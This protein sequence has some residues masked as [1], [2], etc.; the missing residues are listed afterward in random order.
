V[1]LYMHD[2]GIDYTCNKI[3]DHFKFPKYFPFDFQQQRP[4]YGVVQEC[5]YNGGNRW[6]REQ[7]MMGQGHPSIFIGPAQSESMMHVDARMTRFWMAMINGTKHWHMFHPRDIPNLYP[8]D[9][10]FFP[11][12]FDVDTFR[13]DLKK[14]PKL[15]NAIMWV[16]SIRRGDILFIPEGW[17]HQ[18]YNPGATV[19][20]AYNYVDR[21][22]FH[23]WKQWYHRDI[24]DELKSDRDEKEILRELKEQG[25]IIPRVGQVRLK[26]T[27]GQ[28]VAAFKRRGFDKSDDENGISDE[29]LNHM[30]E[31]A[32]LEVIY[33]DQTALLKF[34]NGEK[35]DFPFEAIK[36]QVNVAT[37]AHSGGV[38]DDSESR[39][40]LAVLMNPAF[41]QYYVAPENHTEEHFRDYVKR[42][43]WRLLPLSKVT[44]SGT[45]GV[46][47]TARSCMFEITQT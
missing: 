31:E 18:V 16:V 21:H 24:T 33:K 3:F 8:A 10:D 28:I 5:A 44:I 9:H 41:P 17:P 30:G 25:Y 7:N 46:A 23:A 12:K 6:A 14:Y 4:E 38:G 11:A 15:K 35:L 32:F 26:G 34:T 40:E 2:A 39:R 20:L 19:A 47:C 37:G 42:Q 1:K 43:K 36:E 13:P 22:N 27:K 29:K 45:H